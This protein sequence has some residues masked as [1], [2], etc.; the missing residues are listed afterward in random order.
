MDD[1][2]GGDGTGLNK[3]GRLGVGG[4]LIIDVVSETLNVM[5]VGLW[6]QKASNNGRS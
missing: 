2:E 4:D 6:G 3:V 5:M 1:Q